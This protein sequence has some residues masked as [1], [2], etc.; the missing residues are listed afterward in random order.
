MRTLEGTAVGVAAA[1]AA[2]AIVDVVGTADSEP[3]PLYFYDLP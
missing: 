1:A 3:A 2:A